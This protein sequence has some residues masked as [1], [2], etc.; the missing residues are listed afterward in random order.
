[1]RA[2]VSRSPRGLTYSTPYYVASG[3]HERLNYANS[4][5]GF[6]Q[7]F[8]FPLNNGADAAIYGEHYY[9]FD[10]GDP[11]VNTGNLAGQQNKADIQALFLQYGVDIVFEGHDHYYLRHEEDGIQYDETA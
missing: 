4:K 11:W 6:D 8:T 3:N 10:N 2:S 1:M 5:A 9:S 7:E